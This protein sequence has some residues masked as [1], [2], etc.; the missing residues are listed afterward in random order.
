MTNYILSRRDYD[1]FSVEVIGIYETLEKAI[2]VKPDLNF[3][4]SKWRQGEWV[5]FPSQDPFIC[6]AI[7]RMG[8]NHE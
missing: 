5:A 6:Y 1:D 2:K 4:E 3:K 7:D 8:S